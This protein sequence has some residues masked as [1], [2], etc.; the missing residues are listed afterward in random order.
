MSLAI[1]PRLLDTKTMSDLTYVLFLAMIVWL[2][3]YLLNSGG[4]SGG[5]RC[6][7][8]LG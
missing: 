1:E 3:D 2:A 5:R 6:R 4:G 8:P 7:V